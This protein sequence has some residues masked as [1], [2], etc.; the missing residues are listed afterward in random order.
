[1]HK[2]LHA[3]LI[4]FALGATLLPLS[5]CDQKG[6]AER[7]GEKIDQGGQNLRDAIDPPKG[8]AEQLGRSVDRATK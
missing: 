4:A 6:P 2:N 8:P 3:A 7:T 1:M 5:A